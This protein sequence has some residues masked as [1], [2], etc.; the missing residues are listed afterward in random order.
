MINR[1]IKICLAWHNFNSANYGV[2]ALAIAHFA[3]IV[4]AAENN[5]IELQV[6]TLGTPNNG[7]LRIREEIEERFGLKIKHID[8]SLRDIAKGLVKFDLSLFRLFNKYDIVFDIGEGDSFSDIYGQKRF[9]LLSITKI[10]SLMQCRKSVTAP[11][12]I[13]P[14]NR[15]I[16]SIIARKL[17]S[18]SDAVY[19]RDDKSSC[20]L[21]ELKVQHVLVSD[22]AFSLPFDSAETFKNAIGLNVSGLL[23]NGGYNKNNQFGLTVDYQCLIDEII[24]RFLAR[25]KIIHLIAHVI[26]DVVEVED[27]YRVCENIKSKHHGDARVVLAPKFTSPIAAKSYISRMEFFTGARMHAT[28]AAI[29]SGVPTVPVAYSRKFSGVFGSLGYHYTI[30]SYGGISTD[31]F[32]IKLFD[33][34]DEHLDSMKVDVRSAT[35]K[36][37]QVN[38]KYRDFLVE[39]MK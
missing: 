8:Y 19:V 39:I 21:N 33:Y 38:S 30:N 12:T 9:L 14:F 3:M 1:K 10:L 24:K 13:G 4:E 20:Y 28:I 23:W 22:V 37:H 26:A 17:L 15:K 29:S 36:A 6:D 18:K 11:Q 25:G 5:N 7:E 16:S 32:L 34:Y 31:D 2:G 35:G 27:D